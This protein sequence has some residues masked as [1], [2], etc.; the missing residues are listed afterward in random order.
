MDMTI[1]NGYDRSQLYNFIH[2]SVPT[3]H[4]HQQQ[5]SPPPLMSQ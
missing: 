3:Q 1:N 4:A 2:L 5:Q